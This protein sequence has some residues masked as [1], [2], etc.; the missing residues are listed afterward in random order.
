M[1]G[2]KMK[3]EN[4]VGAEQSSVLEGELLAGLYSQ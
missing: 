4:V 2:M 3:V 1:G